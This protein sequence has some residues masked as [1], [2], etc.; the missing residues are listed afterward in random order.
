M[1]AS[2]YIDLAKTPISSGDFCGQDVR[3]TAEFEALEAELAKADSLY[4]TAGPDWSAVREGS[5]NLLHNHSKDLRAAV[6]LT[7]SLYQSDSFNGLHAG[8]AALFYL[9][10]D[11]WDDLYPRKLRTRQASFNWL[12][13]R[14]GQTLEA[15]PNTPSTADSTTITAVAEQLRQL[16]QC[17]STH[18]PTDAPVLLPLCRRLDELAAQAGK[19]GSSSPVLDQPLMAATVLPLTRQTAAHPGMIDN[20]RNAHKAMRSLQEQGRCLCDWWLGES[21]ANPRAIRLSRTLLWLPV[22]SLPEHNAQQQTQLRGPSAD[23]LTG[24]AERFAREQYSEMLRELEASVAK[25]PFWLDGQRM[26]FDC[27]EALGAK[28]AMRELEEQ[29]RL[30]LTRLP[31]LKHLRFHDGIAFADDCTQAWLSAKVQTTTD[32]TG[33]TSPSTVE[34]TEQAPWENALT[35]AVEL[36]RKQ[37]LKIAVNLLKQGMHAAHN[38]RERFHWQLAQARL[39]HQGRHYEFAIYQLEALYKTLQDAN[40][41]RWEPDLAIRTFRLLADSYE[42]LPRKKSAA[43]RIDQIYQRLCHL[44]LEAALDQTPRS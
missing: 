17:L 22:D 1:L 21:L 11:H 9:C 4:D 24:Y 12:L 15:K 32:N 16:D 14:L 43:E 19:R 8:I 42:H 20:A 6:W 30:L 41:E 40:L 34:S 25:S 29:V 13:P 39:C 3:Y 2:H 28:D 7:W 36:M 27:L 35:T 44:D 38:E 31:G 26:V 33:A 5:T 23:Q 10:S 18:M 37:N